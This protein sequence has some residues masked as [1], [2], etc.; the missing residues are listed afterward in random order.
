MVI[1]G[2]RTRSGEKENKNPRFITIDNR[3]IEL[4]EEL[5]ELAAAI[6]RDLG[7]IP[8]QYIASA[9]GKAGQG[10]PGLTMSAAG[11]GAELSA[12][13]T[14]DEWD[15]RR[16]GFRLNWCIVTEKKIPIT[17]STFIRNTLDAYHGQIIRLRHQ[18]EMMRTSE[19]FVRRQRDGDDIDLD[20][21]VESLADTVAGRPPS[22]RLFI[23]LKRDERDI[24][25][26][27][28][29]DMSNSTRGWV[30][31]AIKESLVLI[32]EAMET[33]GD[34]YGIYGFSGM[35]RLRCEIFPIKNID[36]A[37]NDE[38]RERIGSIAPREYTRMAPA[39]RH[40]TS[41]LKDVDAKV[42]LLITLSDGKP[43]DYDEYKGEYAIEDTRHALIEAKMAG[44]H[45]FCITIDQHAHEYMAHMYGEVNYIFINDVRKLPARMPEIYRVLTS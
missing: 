12:P 39:I 37:Y 9:A 36:Q 28:L 35:R 45:P 16:S 29:V 7:T 15:F 6:T 30:G 33:L 8:D 2:S 13:I 22:D 17:R 32:C 14:Y 44:I 41:I 38:V 21:L 31:K 18:F 19:R 24:A 5:A 43:E 3:E 23:R 27:F 4:S 34:R 40:M 42:R 10:T 25:A 1:A 20:A 26:L 11:D